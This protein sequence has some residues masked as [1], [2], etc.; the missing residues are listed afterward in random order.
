MTSHFL[1]R[2][3]ALILVSAM[4]TSSVARAENEAARF[5]ATLSGDWQG[6]RTELARNGVEFGLLATNDAMAV[7]DGGLERDAFY[8]GLVEP[9]IGFDLEQLL[10][11][12][13]T[14]VFIR[15]FGMYGRDPADAAGALDTPSN[16][17]NS[18]QTFVVYEA[19]IER[20]FLDERLGVRAGLYAADSEF[21]A[22]GVSAPFLNSGF[23][24]GIDLSQT[25]LNGPCIYPTSCLGLR[26]RYDWSTNQYVQVAVMDAVAGDPDDPYGTHVIV[27]D[28]EGVLT[29]AETGYEQA[30]ESGRFLRAAA[31]LWYYSSEFDEL[32]RVDA[33]GDP[34]RSRPRP[35]AYLLLEGELHR[36]TP[37]GAQGLNGVVRFGTADPDHY[38]TEYFASVALTYTGLF[39]G[40]DADLL[41]LGVMVP[42]NGSPYERAQRET[43]LSVD[44]AE[45]A[46]ELTYWF[47]VLDWLSLQ[48]DAQYI[49]NPGT[50]PRIEDALVLGLRSRIV[51]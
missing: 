15:G 24:V 3:A 12:D 42:I 10:G 14:L 19:W 38:Q 20:R 21:D 34:M 51:F 25:G 47:P 33:A 41:G 7:V 23:G 27:G 46:W 35:G 30:P 37:D 32:L 9:S 39:A 8:P 40:R 45:V 29:L 17:G 5:A 48:L 16:I 11:W 31:G 36:E 50:D 49:V 44:S 1:S 13:E 6:L 26:V 4:A 18:A 43:G 2:G 22:K 28:G